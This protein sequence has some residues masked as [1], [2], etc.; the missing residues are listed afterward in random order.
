[1]KLKELHVG[2]EVYW[3]D[4]DDGFSSGYYKVVSLPT[5]PLGF[6]TNEEVADFEEDAIILIKNEAG[7]EAEVFLHEL[8]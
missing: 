6:F 5:M 3:T 7:S 1:M 8:S 4:P 2:A